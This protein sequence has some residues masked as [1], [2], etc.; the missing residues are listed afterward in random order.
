VSVIRRLR[1]DDEGTS[2]V[3]FMILLLVLLGFAA[4]AIDG[5]AAWSQRRQNQSAADTAALAGGI[6]IGQ[7]QTPVAIASATSEVIRISYETIDPD[8]SFAD[9]STAWANCTDPNR[10]AEFT[11]T[12][13]SQCVS[14]TGNLRKIRVNMPRINVET[15]FG[16][17]LGRDFIGT[18]AVAEAGTKASFDG[19]VLP[20]GLPWSVADSTEVCLKTGSNPQSVAPCDGPDEGNFGF[21]DITTFGPPSKCSGQTA[22]RLAR[23]IMEGADH[24]LDIAAT[25]S[26]PPLIDIDVCT[27]GD[28]AVEPYTVTTETGNMTGVLHEGLITGDPSDGIPGRLTVGSNTI[29]IDGN[30]VDNTPLAG[31]LND[32]GLAL[33][34]LYPATK[35]G[36]IDCL[37]DEWDDTMD[38][39]FKKEISTSPRFAWVPLFWEDDLG[40]GSTDRTI[41]EF[42]PVY[43]QTTL[44]KC[45]SNSCKYVHDPGET[46]GGS[47]GGGGGSTEIEA[48]SGIQLPPLSLHEDIRE[49]QPGTDGD[50][51]FVLLK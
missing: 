11:L 19:G 43:L 5:A 15:T 36:I 16:R 40:T 32:D 31:F 48:L 45:T 18:G 30:D 1:Q 37:E 3:L 4:I 23:N 35:A 28:F 42:R 29:D 38:P 50:K 17:V 47:G 8:V 14:F 20:F 41:R 34:A 26:E 21:L 12:G 6:F 33:C 22:E 7:E 9:W 2:L 27:D 51:E 49:A 13:T 25:D 10:P 44:W 39:I 24:F 46:M